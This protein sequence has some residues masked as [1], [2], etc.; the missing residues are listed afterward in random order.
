MRPKRE[1]EPEQEQKRKQRTEPEPK[2]GPKLTVLA[3]LDK[4]LLD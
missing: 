1:P 2:E 4:V 3:M